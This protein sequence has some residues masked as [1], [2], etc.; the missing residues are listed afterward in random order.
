M[1]ARG[2]EDGIVIESPG[3]KMKLLGMQ[4]FKK[5]KMVPKKRESN[6]KV[7]IPPH[8]RKKR[9]F[10]IDEQFFIDFINNDLEE[11]EH[12]FDEEKLRD[13]AK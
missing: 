7:Y 2:I 12:M 11:L 13:I 5:K 4:G 8:M 1:A 10:R 9:K 6:S 3:K